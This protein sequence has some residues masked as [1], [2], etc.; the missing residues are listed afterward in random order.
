MANDSYCYFL[1]QQKK[2]NGGGAGGEAFGI[3]LKP[4]LRELKQGHD[5]SP[6]GAPVQL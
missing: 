4:C 3:F 2:V 6:S 1:S 5:P